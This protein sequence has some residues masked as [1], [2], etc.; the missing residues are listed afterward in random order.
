MEQGRRFL[1]NPSL[2][3][4]ETAYTT[5]DPKAELLVKTLLQKAAC[6]NDIPFEHSNNPEVTLPFP[7]ITKDESY[8]VFS[9]PMQ[10]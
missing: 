6:M 9:K 4:G 7:P 8:Q 1:P 3:N 5:S 10:Y 2:K